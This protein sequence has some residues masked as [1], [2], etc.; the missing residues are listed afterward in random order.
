MLMTEKR[1]FRLAHDEARR[2]AV[3]CILQ[4]PEGYVVRVS[5]P[6]RSLE[7]N[8]LMW[9]LLTSISKCVLWPVNGE[10]T[11]LSPEDWK[12]IFTAALKRHVRMSAGIDGG[13]VMLGTST[14]RLGKREFSDL[15]EMIHSFCAERGIE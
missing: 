4:A 11:L 10:M 9:E 3:E 8:A 15:I 7:Q 1:I 13:V 12:Q 5:P 6:T 14:S 2:R